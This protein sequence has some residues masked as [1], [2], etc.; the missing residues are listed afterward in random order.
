MEFMSRKRRFQNALLFPFQCIKDE[1]DFWAATKDPLR[2]Q[3]EKLFSILRK[4]ANTAYGKKYKFNSI[5]S[6]QDFQSNVPITTYSQLEPYI[7]RMKQGE[8]AVLTAEKPVFFATTS[9][10]TGIQKT[11]P[12]TRS[13]VREYSRGTNIWANH[14]FKDY[15]KLLTGKILHLVGPAL[16]GYTQTGLPVGSSSGYFAEIAPFYEKRLMAVPNWVY[17][18]SDLES[19]YYL[20]ARLSL[21]ENITGIVTPNP[22]AILVLLDEINKHKEKLVQE[23]WD[24]V[25]DDQITERVREKENEWINQSYLEALNRLKPNRRRAREL[26]R[27]LG[28]QKEISPKSYWPNLQVISCFTGSFAHFFLKSISAIFRDIPVRDLGYISTEGRGS[29]CLSNSG[30]EGIIALSSHFFEYIPADQRDN[31]EPVALTCNQLQVG[32]RYYVLLTASNGLYRY[33]IN[34]LIEVTGYYKQIPII[35]F[36][37]RGGNVLSLAGEK[38]TE[39]QLLEAVAVTEQLTH[40]QVDYL[41]ATYQWKEKPRYVFL[42]A[43]SEQYERREVEV[44]LR[45]LEKELNTLNISYARKRQLQSLD[46]P[47]LCVV[48]RNDFRDFYKR[49]P[50]KGGHDAQI[51]HVVLNKDPNI[52]EHFKVLWT[53]TL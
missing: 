22:G 32:H 16:D 42:V 7:E 13:F 20:I 25:F 30:A 49:K 24:G 26:E 21:P 29:I 8:Q 40:L 51:K 18:V 3:R 28:S 14:L 23:I 12:F 43:F 31:N 2:A 27:L 47:Q 11:I 5:Q 48:S 35:K 45:F 52:I 1:I 41:I 50:T 19:K 33:D 10:T 46:T 4:N 38:L 15:P 53:M 9:G 44:F 6:I 17:N 37:D 34:D 36:I 39:E